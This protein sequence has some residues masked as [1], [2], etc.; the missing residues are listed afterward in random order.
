MSRRRSRRLGT[1]SGCRCSPYRRRRPSSRS[2]AR[3][4]P[5]SPPTRS[6]RRPEISRHQGGSQAPRCSKGAAGSSSLSL[7]CSRRRWSPSTVQGAAADS[8]GTGATRL[9]TGGDLA[10]DSPT[11]G[12]P[13]QRQPTFSHVG[14][15]GLSGR[16]VL[17]SRTGRRF[18]SSSGPPAARFQ[19]AP[20]RQSRGDAAV[21]P[22]RP[23]GALH[24][25]EMRLRRM[26]FRSLLRP[27]SDVDL[28]LLRY[29]GFAP[30]ARSR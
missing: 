16:Q 25:A 26:L 9:A 11:H 8:A 12:K 18:P 15:E 27:G 4:S 6:P 2:R 19:P 14:D 24:E 5:R 7:A 21:D 30:T 29:V 10:G 20:A 1:S 22:P 17:G 28:S 13:T 3:S 23:A